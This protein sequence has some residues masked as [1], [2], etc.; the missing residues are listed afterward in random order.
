MNDRSPTVFVSYSHDSPEHSD[1]VADLA[2]RLRGNGVEVIFD[3]TDLK[4]GQDIAAFM[5]SGVSTADRVLVVCTDLYVKKADAGEGGVGYEKMIVTAELVSDLGTRK[6]IPVLRQNSHGQAMPRFMGTR[7]YVD[8][9][10]DDGEA[11]M[12]LLEELHDAPSSRKSALGSSPFADPVADGLEETVTA[13]QSGDPTWW[14]TPIDGSSSFL[15]DGAI[16]TVDRGPFGGDPPR[17]IQWLNDTQI[18]LRLIP[19]VPKGFSRSQMDEAIQGIRPMSRDVTDVWIGRNEHGANAFVK[20]GDGDGAQVQML[21]QLFPSGELWGIHTHFFRRKFLA[22]GTMSDIFRDTLTS[23]LSGA[24]RLQL[25]PPYT[26]I[27]GIS[28]IK[29]KEVATSR[30]E[31][32]GYCVDNELSV[33]KTVE[34]PSQVEPNALLSDLY[35]AIYDS[36]GV[37]RGER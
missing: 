3:K 27:A 35:I 33:R 15:A 19:S 8:P 4:L 36:A 1:W 18:F 32:S 25:E 26:A 20:I 30:N 22:M 5:E 6:F 34:G 23:Y 12:E 29:G 10:K 21:S 11:F 16:V 13:E 7:K 9:T 14:T 37:P 24:Q 28:G 2:R 17:E 31:T